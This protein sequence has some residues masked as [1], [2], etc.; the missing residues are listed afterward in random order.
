[1]VLYVGGLFRLIKSR[2]EEYPLNSKFDG[3]FNVNNILTII[4]LAI[5]GALFAKADF[6]LHFRLSYVFVGGD[7]WTSIG[8]AVSV[9][10]NHSPLY[11]PSISLKATGSVGY[12]CL[13]FTWL[14]LFFILSGVPFINATLLLAPIFKVVMLSS[15][16]YAIKVLFDKNYEKFIPSLAV[17][18][19]FCGGGFFWLS[20]LRERAF[21]LSG[22]LLEVLRPANLPYVIKK[23][24]L[25][26]VLMVEFPMFVDLI[27]GFRSLLIGVI[28]GSYLFYSTYNYIRE[29]EWQAKVQDK[30]DI[31]RIAL[32]MLAASFT[33]YVLHPIEVTIFALVVIPLL[34]IFSE[35]LNV[36]LEKL[37]RVI[38]VVLLGILSVALIDS[39]S[40]LRYFMFQQ[41]YYIVLI[42][43]TLLFL[44]CKVKREKVIFVKDVVGKKF[45][46][47]KLLRWVFAFLLLYFYSSTFLL[48]LDSSVESSSYLIIPW[49]LYSIKFGIIGLLAVICIFL[50]VSGK[51]RDRRLSLVAIY[52]VSLYVI[53]VA[54]KILNLYVFFSEFR[55]M[56]YIFIGCAILASYFLNKFTGTLREFISEKRLSYRLICS[57]LLLIIVI[58]SAI[59][60]S[61][62]TISFWYFSK[63]WQ[64]PCNVLE[65]ETSAIKY[66]M[67]NRPLESNV[68]IPSDYY[69]GAWIS[70]AFTVLSGATNNYI[71]YPE[72]LLE[73][74]DP[75]ALMYGLKALNVWGIYTS[76][77][78]ISTDILTKKPL[79]NKLS[80]VAQILYEDEDV[81]I[82]GPL[83]SSN[84]AIV[85]AGREKK[86]NLGILLPISIPTLYALNQMNINYEVVN[87]QSNRKNMGQLIILL[88][89]FKKYEIN[90]ERKDLIKT[91]NGAKLLSNLSRGLH[92]TL[93]S[94]KEGQNWPG[95]FIEINHLSW[96]PNCIYIKY[97]TSNLPLTARWYYFELLDKDSNR[98]Y[99]AELPPTGGV[100]DSQI[101]MML[102]QTSKKP[103]KIFIGIDLKSAPKAPPRIF[104]EELLFIRLP[105]YDNFFFDSRFLSKYTNFNVK[106]LLDWVNAGGEIIVIGYEHGVFA[107]YLNIL[108]ENSSRETKYVY[109]KDVGDGKI[110][111]IDVHA[112]TEKNGKRYVTSKLEKLLRDILIERPYSLTTSKDS[113][114]VC[115]LY[116]FFKGGLLLDGNVILN[117]TTIDGFFKERMIHIGDSIEARLVKLKISNFD[118][119][120]YRHSYGKQIS[121]LIEG[122]KV[123]IE[124]G[125]AGK[126]LVIK[127]LNAKD[128][129]LNHVKV[130]VSSPFIIIVQNPTNVIFTGKMKV[131]YAI[132]WERTPVKIDLVAK[133]WR[134]SAEV[135]GSIAF[136]VAFS[137]TYLYL[138]DSDFDNAKINTK[139]TW[140]WWVLE[141]ELLSEDILS[142]KKILFLDRFS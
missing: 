3:K 117:T 61:Y 30:E 113:E 104:I 22:E 93:S 70:R 74:K 106:A 23:L 2:R 59:S 10:R 125:F 109:S 20:L 99:A 138:L 97:K 34:F 131:D 127:I 69:W 19:A 142:I 26:N 87:L 75:I 43:L 116:D 129:S 58:F 130:K 62:M 103:S 100:T 92:V 40:P 63:Q 12:P 126:Y 79:I 6:F 55:F 39:I 41:S 47:F 124:G 44:L 78:D 94:D 115:C 86:Q 71:L 118:F 17:F 123:V 35:T 141:E 102:P 33:G 119:D 85:M 13:F 96:K 84:H 45:A 72:V 42:L 111:Y 14:A 31:K 25:S 133:V 73:E 89:D 82:L 51:W 56:W 105:I 90:F 53:V 68:L 108:E 132:I 101:Y 88:E 91:V 139:R 57:Y 83:T 60:E 80:S 48:W 8:N 140:E 135:N 95:I 121:L 66:M 27:F 46:K 50:I 67:D 81:K 9:I 24:S 28:C 128:I 4:P 54:V 77:N 114:G 137:G 136:N 98:I 49:Y 21:Q 65:R 16:Y 38:I 7:M 15:F 76:K 64:V 18:F 1:M 37:N 5:A 110:V 134:S 120:Q 29:K 52:I 122:G 11:E 112:F 32:P 36:S 107:E